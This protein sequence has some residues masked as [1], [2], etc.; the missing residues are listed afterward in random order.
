MGVTDHQRAHPI[1]RQK[2]RGFARRQKL[3]CVSL[4]SNGRVLGGLFLPCDR[5]QGDNRGLQTKGQKMVGIAR[6][7]FKKIPKILG[8]L[9][10]TCSNSFAQTDTTGIFYCP[11][12]INAIEL[13]H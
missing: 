4:Q 11:L 13:I 9:L 6:S 3:D 5:G 12:N 8:S 1:I 7:S 10:L 2:P